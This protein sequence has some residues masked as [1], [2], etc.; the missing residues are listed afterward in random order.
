[1]QSTT[2]AK[3][4]ADAA[5]GKEPLGVLAGLHDVTTRWAVTHDIAQW[6]D[7]IAWMSLYF[8]VA[9]WSSLALCAFG[10]VQDRVA[11]CRARAARPN[12]ARRR[13]EGVAAENRPSG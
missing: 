10:L 9:V 6:K 3:W 8:S 4:Q 7:E 11:H 12:P 5:S 2:A 13:H 1:M